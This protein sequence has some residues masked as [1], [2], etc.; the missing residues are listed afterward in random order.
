[1][2]VTGVMIYGLLMRRP[3]KLL[4]LGPDSLIV[5]VTYILGVLFLTM[6]PG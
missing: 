6:V 5:L 2:S 4:A 3:R 1:M